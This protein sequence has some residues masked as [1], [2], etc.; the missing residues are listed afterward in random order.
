[1]WIAY[2]LSRVEYDLGRATSNNTGADQFDQPHNLVALGSV[3]LPEIWNGLS[4]GFR[5]RYTTGAPRW[6]TAG[7]LY[8]VDA[9]DYRSLPRDRVADERLPDFFQLDLRVDKRWTFDTATLT[10]Y[11]DVQNVTNRENSEGM[12]YNY[13][14]TKS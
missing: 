4:F 1:G 8:D 13:D 7:G 5:A 14:F 11:L 3:E 12:D 2:T 6:R 10:A 9:D